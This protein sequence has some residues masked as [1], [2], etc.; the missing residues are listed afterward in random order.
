MPHSDRRGAAIPQLETEQTD[1]EISVSN[2]FK[3]K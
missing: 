2:V 3:S 1:M